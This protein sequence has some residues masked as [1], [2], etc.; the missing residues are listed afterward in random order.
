M[1]LGIRASTNLH[2]RVKFENVDRE[3]IPSDPKQPGL[4]VVCMEMTPDDMI[5]HDVILGII[6]DLIQSKIILGKDYLL[7]LLL[8]NQF[9]IQDRVKV[10]R[11]LN[12]LI[13]NQVKF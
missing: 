11:L 9:L 12:K 1:K 13:S 2:T 8:R 3:L 10:L 7:D 4:D 6:Q 5:V